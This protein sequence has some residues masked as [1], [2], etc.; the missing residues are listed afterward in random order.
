MQNKN[1]PLAY[2][3]ISKKNLIYNIKQFS[4]IVS[5][6]TKII[7]VLKANA[8]GHGLSEVAKILN[9][10]TNYFQVNNIQELEVLRKITKKKIFVFGYIQKSDLKRVIKLNCILSAFSIDHLIEI[11]QQAGDLDVK[12]EIHIPIDAYLGREGFLLNELQ[13]ALEKIKRSEFLKLTGI[14]AHF[15]NIEDT[16]DFSHAEKQI[17]EYK[18]ALQIAEKFGFNNLQT[19]ISATSGILVYERNQGINCMIRIGMGT[20]GLWPSEHLKK[21]NNNKS[22]NLKPVLTWRTKIS[23]IK[24]LPKGSTI[25]Y[26]LTYRTKKETKVAII[27]QG[28]SDGLDRKLSN[29]GEVLIRGTRCKILGRVMM[30][31]FVVDVSHLVNVKIEDE[32]I[33]IG[34]QGK[35]EI[36]IEEI[37]LKINTINYEV[38]ARINPLLPKIVV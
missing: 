38:V 36:T 34:K 25:G 11:N 3:E 16:S 22:F 17:N 18:K 15:A 2:I 23:Q 33:I 6:N 13:K 29:K 35:E 19:H 20:Y 7:L 28:Y 37:S 1:S 21:V 31:M 14:Y 10:H 30:N 27:P 26:G 24:I 5:K 4:K 12:Q 8:Y 32:V 9:P